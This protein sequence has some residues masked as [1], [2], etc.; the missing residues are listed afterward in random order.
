MI[1]YKDLITGDELFSDSFPCT[2]VEDLYYEV[3]G[4]HTTESDDIDESKLGANASAEEASEQLEKNVKSGVNIVLANKLEQCFA[5]SQDE[6][7]QGIFKPYVKKIKKLLEEQEP[8]KAAAFPE[9]AKQLLGLL[10]KKLK[11]E[12]F[13][14]YQGLSQTNEAMTA[15]L[16]YKEK[17]GEEVP[18]MI[19]F[20][21]GL[22]EMKV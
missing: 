15:L 3:I 2:L 5:I 21:D 7:L 10:K 4:K 8:D 14:F 11:N 19:F 9:R 1:I 17:D 20:K 22:T 13:D 6:Y 16:G 18:Y 12:E